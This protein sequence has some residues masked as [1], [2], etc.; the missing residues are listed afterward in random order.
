MIIILL[1]GISTLFVLPVINNKLLI[2]GD[3]IQYHLYRIGELVNNFKHGNL[4]PYLYSYSFNKIGS[5]IGIFYPQVTLIPIAFFV[6]ITGKFSTGIYLG[7]FFY[8]FLTV[9][10]T[11]IVARKFKYNKIQS[12]F[13]SIIYC[14]CTYRTIDIYTR[15]ALGEF[16][17]MTF[18]PLIVYGLYAVMYGNQ[19]DWPFLALG[20][21][22]I[23]FSHYLSTI[24]CFLIAGILF[25]LGFYWIK[26]KKK[27]SKYGL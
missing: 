15:F 25:I 27:E 13:A 4:Y 18:L 14:F 10:F 6:L 9:S 24:I 20:F 22:G 5:A 8:T 3:D 12:I 16:L 19:K 11:Y 2:T 23:L 1:L 26:D 17:A 7:V 21:A